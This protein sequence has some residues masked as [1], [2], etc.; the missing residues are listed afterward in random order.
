MKSGTKGRIKQG[1]DWGRYEKGRG[2]SEKGA[3]KKK[4]GRVNDTVKTG[5]WGDEEKNRVAM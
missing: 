1:S 4:E 3:W 5:S 2:G